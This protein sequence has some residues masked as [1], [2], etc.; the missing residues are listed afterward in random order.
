MSFALLPSNGRYRKSRGHGCYSLFPGKGSTG[1]AAALSPC[2]PRGL[3]RTRVRDDQRGRVRG[4]DPARVR[5]S[6]SPDGR[7]ERPAEVNATM[8]DFLRRL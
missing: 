4:Q 1:S 7:E 5:R 6:P 2:R 8:I 3:P